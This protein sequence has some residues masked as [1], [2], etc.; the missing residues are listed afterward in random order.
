MYDYL[1]LDRLNAPAYKHLTYHWFQDRLNLLSTQYLTTMAIGVALQGRPVG[2]VLVEYLKD[3]HQANI[4]SLVVAPGH[5]QRGIGTALLIQIEEKL[6]ASGCQQIDFIYNLNLTTPILERMLDRQN[7]TPGSA[8]SLQ[9]STNLETIEQAPFLNRYTFPQKFT[10][11]PWS[12]LTDLE[13]SKIEHRENGLN[14]PDELCPFRSGRI[15][16]QSSIGVRDSLSETLRERDEV[17]GW[18]I[19][20]QLSP[21]CVSY[22]S[23]FVKPEYRSIGL[24][25]HL[26]VASINRQIVDRSVTA[27]LFIVLQ[28]NTAMTKFMTRHL[29]PYLTAINTY[30][31]SSK[32]IQLPVS[33]DRD[34]ALSRSL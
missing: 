1:V 19:V 10:I 30:W 34:L 7:W 4:L 12:E 5:R 13:R 15:E 3:R 31:K 28:E 8:H 24:G 26:L 6:T 29:A 20:E 23:L 16:A 32:L 9:C 18:S 2:L 11:F 17:I 25:L 14:Y 27:G 33:S 22:S 21:N